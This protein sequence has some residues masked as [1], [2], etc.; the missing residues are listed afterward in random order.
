MYTTLLVLHAVPVKRVKFSK[1]TPRLQLSLQL[2]N[3]IY[4][5]IDYLSSH[6]FQCKTK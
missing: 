5:L 1:V 6:Y 4:K 3:L 2:A